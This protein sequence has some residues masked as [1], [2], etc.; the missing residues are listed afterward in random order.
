MEI[1]EVFSL[2]GGLALFLYGMQM[3]SNGLETAAGNKMKKILEKLTASRIKGVIIGALI[4]AVINSSSATTVMVVGFVNSGLMT[5]NQA[6]WIIMGANIGSTIT[7]QLIALD[8][9]AV[10]PFIAFIAVAMI[11]FVKNEKVKHIS[12]IFAGLGILFIGM[13]MMSDAMVPFQESETF[14]SFMANARNP[15]VGILIGAVFTAVVQSSAA[16]VG[17]LQALAKAGIVPLSSAVYILFGQNIGTCITAVLA[18][19]GTKTNAK[20]TTVIHLMFNIIGS[21]LFTF[22]CIFTP[23]VKIMSSFPSG[24][25]VAQIANVHTVFNIATTLMLLPFGTLMAKAA[26]LILPDSKKEDDEELK[27]VHIKKFESN[28]SVGNVALAISQI[29]GEIE[30]MLRMVIQNI[31]GSFDALLNKDY[32]GYAKLEEREDY[33]DYLN[34]EISRYV[35]RCMGTEMEKSDSERIN[36]YYKIVSNMERLGD[37][38]MNFLGYAHDMREWEIEFSNY[39]KNE[40]KEMKEISIKTLEDISLTQFPDK[41]KMLSKTAKNE[42]KIDDL[43]EMY[44]KEQINRMKIGTCNPETGIIFSEILTDFERIGDHALNI[45]KQYNEMQ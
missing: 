29:E 3:M 33:I 17:I 44:L 2:L 39:A 40:I 14:I 15:V 7:G 13:G 9:G 35:V 23:F 43:D 26:T 34:A 21:T 18:S 30:R 12:E 24:D 41:S 5:L 37:H 1:T 36:A 42:Q 32:K 4:T 19:I 28:Y 25:V 10:A 11:M 27:L 45:A 16:S 6:V 20:R 8:I 38:A 31:E 22:I